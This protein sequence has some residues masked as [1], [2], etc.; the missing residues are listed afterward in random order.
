VQGGNGCLSNIVKPG[1]TVR[2]H[3]T[4]TL[5]DGSEFDSSRKREPL[6]FTVGAGELIPGFESAVI[7]MKPGEKKSITLPPEQA[8]G[9]HRPEL[10]AEIPRS[11]FPASLMPVVDQQVEVH[12]Q[13]GQVLL[14]TIVAVSEQ[15]VTLD[16][17]HP[18][19]GEPLTFA[20][21]LVEIL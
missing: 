5:S 4:G 15:V 19:A 2:V 10:V 21:E 11:E 16:A 12:T 17:N 14:A 9:P 20:L 8:Y 6:E 3:Y 13:E 1:D 18:L 7:G